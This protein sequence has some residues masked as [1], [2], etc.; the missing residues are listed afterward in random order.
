M[1]GPVDGR[2]TNEEEVPAATVAAGSFRFSHLAGTLN[3]HTRLLLQ[4]RHRVSISSLET[5]IIPENSQ[6]SGPAGSTGQ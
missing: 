1:G 3:E 5:K 2:N 6:A 4:D